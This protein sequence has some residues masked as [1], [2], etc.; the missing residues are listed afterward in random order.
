MEE[1]RI[2]GMR[3]GFLVDSMVGILNKH[4]TY[5]QIMCSAGAPRLPISTIIVKGP[6]VLEDLP[7]YGER[8][9]EEETMLSIQNVVIVSAQEIQ[10]TQEKTLFA[11][12]VSC[13]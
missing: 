13:T 7:V 12:A 5:C 4:Q 3:N 6:Q 2:E 1:S 9:D 11:T 8:K 10:F